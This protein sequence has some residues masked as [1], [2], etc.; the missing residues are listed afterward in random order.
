MI[1]AH[2]VGAYDHHFLAT[3]FDKGSAGDR[4]PGTGASRQQVKPLAFVAPILSQTRLA[5]GGEHHIGGNGTHDEGI[6]LAEGR[7]LFF[8][9]ASRTAGTTI[10]EV[11]LPSPYQ[12]PSFIYTGRYRSISHWYLPF[13]PDQSSLACLREHSHQRR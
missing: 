13:F 6:D 1:Q 9:T 10:S 7:S 8:C 12:D 5:V 3:A 11:A 2:F 4:G